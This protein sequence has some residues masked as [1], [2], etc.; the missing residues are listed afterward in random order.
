M[1][2]KG[3]PKIRGVLDLNSI[4]RQ[5]SAKDVMPISDNDFWN[6]D[7]QIALK[8]GYITAIGEQGN[9]TS[10]EGDPD[11]V[12]KLVNKL[13]TPINIP[14]QNHAVPAGAQFT[15]RESELRNPDMR[16]AIAKGLVQILNVLEDETTASEGFLKLGADD[17]EETETHPATPE[18]NLTPAQ[19][20]LLKASLQSQAAKADNP[21]P[22][23]IDTNEELPE[24]KSER[25]PPNIIDT[26]KPDAVKSSDIPDSLGKSVVFNPTGEK[27]IN[28]IKNAHVA[29]PREDGP[30]FVDEEQEK[31]RVESHPKLKPQTKKNE[32]E[33]LDLEDAGTRRNPNL[34]TTTPDEGVMIE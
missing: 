28:V 32:L 27:P 4:K 23:L 17:V 18:S 13:R 14:N 21:L 11:R 1:V 22:K 6:S 8:M 20:A 16:L 5:I 10:A 24:P 9:P 2:I 26:D 30:S 34:P 7:V 33:L 15:M 3:T 25:H 31:E 29:N 19:Q 12:V